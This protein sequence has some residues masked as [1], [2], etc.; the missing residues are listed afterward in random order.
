MI[1]ILQNIITDVRIFFA[2]IVSWQ[3]NVVRATE[4]ACSFSPLKGVT[5]K[6][7]IYIFIC[8]EKI[9]HKRS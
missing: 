7:N 8:G 4:T 2:Y 1:N 6:M 5:V 3:R 9:K